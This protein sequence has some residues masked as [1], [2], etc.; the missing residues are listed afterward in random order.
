VAE[1]DLNQPLH[2]ASL[3]DFKHEL[4]RQRPEPPSDLHR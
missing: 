2:W 3:G 1:V 4:Q